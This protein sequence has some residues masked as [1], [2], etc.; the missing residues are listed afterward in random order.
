MHRRNGQGMNAKPSD[1]SK[2][3]SS[4]RPRVAAYGSPARNA[5]RP[6][7]QLRSEASSEDTG[8]PL[9]SYVCTAADCYCCDELHEASGSHAT[10]LL[11]RIFGAILRPAGI[12]HVRIQP[13]SVTSYWWAATSV[14]YA[15]YCDWVFVPE[16]CPCPF[17]TLA[18]FRTLCTED[19]SPSP[20]S[21]GS[22]QSTPI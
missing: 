20:L 4:R 11:F 8:Q 10:R 14:G 15:R 7:T 16:V 1:A 13:V 3:P 12:H 18:G 5:K 21:L 9:R 22:R 19:P 2:K 17:S 6:K